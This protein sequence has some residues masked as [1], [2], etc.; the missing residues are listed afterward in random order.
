MYERGREVGLEGWMGGSVY[1]VNGG[2]IIKG[3]AV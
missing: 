1:K 2:Y 3:G